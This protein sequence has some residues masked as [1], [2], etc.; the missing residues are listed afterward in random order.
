MSQAA[1]RRYAR[2]HYKIGKN[3]LLSFS[4]EN[5]YKFT[6]LTQIKHSIIFTR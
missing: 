5:Y 4:R 1:S 3:V 6:D 2:N